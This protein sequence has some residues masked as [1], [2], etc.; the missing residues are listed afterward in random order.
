MYRIGI[1]QAR[2]PWRVVAVWA[3][4]LVVGG[5]FAMQLHDRLGGLSL[6]VPGTDADRADELVEEEFAEPIT[7]QDMLVFSS[8]EYT[9]T[10]EPFREIVDEA[11]AAVRDV[12]GVVSVIGPYQEGAT[13]QISDDGHSAIVVIGLTGESEEHQDLVDDLRAVTDPL[14][15]S[16]VQIFL[17]GES[18]LFV[19]LLD[20]EQEGLNRAEMIGLP[21]ALIVLVLA[22]GTLVAAGMPILLALVGVTV[23][24]GLLGAA[25]YAHT[26]DIM[27]ESLAILLGLGVGIDYSLFVLTRFRE[28]LARG[29]D[30]VAAAGMA[31]STTGKAVLFSGITVALSLSGLYLVDNAVFTNLAIAAST[32]VAVMVA[33][34]LSLLP[35]VLGLVGARVDR[36]R[37]LPRRRERDPQRSGSGRSGWVRWAHGV[38]RRPVSAFVASVAVLGALAIP[39]FDLELGFDTNTGL[40][41]RPSGQGLAILTDEFASGAMAPM[42][43]VVHS[44]DGAFDN[45]DLGAV[46]A[47]TEQIGD[48]PDVARTESLTGILNESVGTPTSQALERA[49]AD[50]VAGEV[51]RPVVDLDGGM[52]T[53]VITVITQQPADAPETA[54]LVDDIRSVIGPDATAGTDLDVHVGGMSAT[55]ADLTDEVEAKQPWAIGLIVALSLLLLLVA[56]R[57][58]VLPL[59][60]AVMNIL[61]VGASLGVLVAVVQHGVGADVIGFADIGFVQ[62]FLPLMAFALLFGL[63]MDY[64]VLLVGRMREEWQRTGDNARAVADGLAHTARPITSAAAI[65]V[66]VFASFAAVPIAELQQL[67]L[68]LAVAILIDATLVRTVLVPAT[69][70]LLGGVN[71]WLPHWLGHVLPRV[72][73][74]EGRRD[75]SGEE[76]A[77]REAAVRR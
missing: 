69:M 50:P 53:T 64:E 3:L 13:G 2:H 55:V 77:P 9:A 51:L 35:A 24:L 37:V 21:L 42:S 31:V 52:D 6:T 54:G 67:G 63:S 15:T 23:T 16:D 76:T 11:V 58:A 39:V 28:Q 43:V 22:F 71:W 47:L 73:L 60:A 30:R 20:A 12:D 74:G 17:T 48:H 40:E 8:D 14:A 5:V 44:P 7:E 36:L 29:D 57:S 26:F 65:M 72:D 75:G 10:D 34:A 66:V 25:S 70:R 32:T 68:V 38:M 19:D 27:V 61:G 41:D 1:A 18:P 56:F 45:Q 62:F 59:K 4:L 46:A 49:A 33:V